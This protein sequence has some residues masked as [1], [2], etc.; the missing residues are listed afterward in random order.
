MQPHSSGR[1]KQALLF[2]R[3]WAEAVLRHVE[4]VRA[5]RRKDTTDTRNHER[6]ED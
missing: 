5:I 1:R 6:M 4:R 2:V 3:V